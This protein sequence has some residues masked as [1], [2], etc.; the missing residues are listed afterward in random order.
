MLTQFGC[1][2]TTIWRIFVYFLSRATEVLGTLIAIKLLFLGP[3]IM[4]FRH[5]G[6]FPASE[7]LIG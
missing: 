1:L 7:F 2:L 5:L 6:S 3:T 4:L